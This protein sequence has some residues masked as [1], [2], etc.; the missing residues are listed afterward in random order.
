M[1]GIFPNVEDGGVVPASVPYSYAPGLAPIGSS[2]LYFNPIGCANYLRPE[3][4]N[5]VI[6]LLAGAIDLSQ[7][8]IDKTDPT[9]LA[10]AYRSQRTNFVN[11]AGVT[12]TANAI[13]VAFNPT[14]GTIG[15]LLGTPLV[16]L[17]EGNN[18]GAVTL[19]VDGLG[20]VALTWPDGTP[21][22]AGDILTGGVVVARHDGTAF[23]M[24]Y[25][26][27]PTQIRA[28]TTVV[29][30]TQIFTVS[31]TF[32]VPA[33]VTSAETVVIAGG[34]GGGASGNASAGGLAGNM[35]AGGGA[36]GYAYERVFGLTPGAGIAVT[37]GAGGTAPSAATGGA[38]GSS[39]FGSFSSATGGGGGAWGEN[40]LGAG[41]TGGT[42][43]GG[44]LNIQGGD[45]GFGGTNTSGGSNATQS[46]ILRIY[47]RGGVA[48][49]G[50]SIPSV[51]GT[52]GAGRGYGTGGTGAS[53]GSGLAGG[54]G[55]P[56]I[57]IVRW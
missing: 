48:A 35:G 13:A 45:G 43:T 42:G 30:R 10:R 8:A 3:F 47:G 22:V 41:G 44:D 18:S 52:G 50:F 21:L 7:I 39:S 53:G 24:E 34:G 20:P 1:S 15:Q 31:G 11:A 23:R 17:A 29:N 26:L 57:V 32:T 40:T 9:Q 25:S 14:F 46:D 51:G 19:A 49:G 6:S 33:G 37:V 55:A 12:G 27:S 2:A 5:N 36:G 54:V 4:L 16:F 56:G 28:L 38:G